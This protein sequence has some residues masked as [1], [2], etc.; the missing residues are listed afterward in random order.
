MSVSSSDSNNCSTLAHLKKPQIIDDACDPRTDSE[1]V[2]SSV[3]FDVSS[4]CFHG[5]SDGTLQPM[6]ER[7]D[8]LCISSDDTDIDN[9]NLLGKSFYD[10]FD[11]Y[12]PAI[13]SLCSNGELLKANKAIEAMIRNSG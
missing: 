9:G 7:A 11:T 5:S 2:L 13:A 4:N 6:T 8:N 3:A 1:Q 12:Y 10:D